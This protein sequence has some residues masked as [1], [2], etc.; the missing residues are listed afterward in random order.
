[1][2]SST[3]RTLTVISSP[4]LTTCDVS[5]TRDHPISDTCS[6]PCTPA[7]R[8]T[9]APN[10]RTEVTRPVIT[11]PATI[12]RRISAALARCSSSSSARRETT[13][14]LPPSLY[15]MIRNCVDAPFVRR[16]V[17]PERVD[18]RERAEGALAG[19]AHLVSA[20]HRPFDLAFHR[21]TGLE[22]VFELPLGRGAARQPPGERQPSHG[23][24]HRRPGCGRR[25]RPRDRRRRP[26]VRRSRSWL[27]PCRRRRRT[28]PPGRSRRSCPR[29]SDPSRR[30]SP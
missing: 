23:R 27:R 5:D 16:R 30:A 12:D 7:P 1:M 25:R 21:K 8:S 10:S 24:H 9:N 4:G 6:R 22:R 26:S 11:A 14:F 19:D 29:W 28:P 13:R 17:R 18:L 15:S 3:R 20:L 2:S